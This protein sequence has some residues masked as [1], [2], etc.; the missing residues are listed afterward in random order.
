MTIKLHPSFLSYLNSRSLVNKLSNFQSFVYSHAFG[1]ICNTET[2]L[3]DFIY[4]KEVLRDKF[5]LYRKGRESRR[6]AVCSFALC[7]FI[8]TQTLPILIS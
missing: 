1:V 8:Q 6:G 7:T 4:D 2:W 5:T 3:S